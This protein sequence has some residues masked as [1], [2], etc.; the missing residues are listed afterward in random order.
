MI[1]LATWTLG[2]CYE[3]SDGHQGVGGGGGVIKYTRSGRSSMSGCC[4]YLVVATDV[5][6]FSNLAFVEDYVESL[7]D[8][9]DVEEVTSVAPVSV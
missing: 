7:S 4:A 1:S 2:S 9:L 3:Q 5:I 6:D 8:V